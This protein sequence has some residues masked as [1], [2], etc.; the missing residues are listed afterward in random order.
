MRYLCL[1]SLVLWGISCQ[2]S[3]TSHMDAKALIVET[4]EKETQYF[5]ERNL[6]KWQEQWSQ[7]PFVSKMYMGNTAFKE[8]LGW[9]EINQN[10][11]DHIQEFPDPIPFPKVEQEYTIEVFG[12]TAFVFYA[13]EGE[14]GPIRE[15]RFMVKEG[16]KWKIAR[17][18]TIY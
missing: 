2:S 16:D 4:L 9:K 18:Q 14:Q 5:C 17:M 1:V 7:K 10:T 11:V 13:K 12:E 6:S 8:F 15:T 3:S